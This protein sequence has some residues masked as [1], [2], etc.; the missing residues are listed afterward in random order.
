M[1]QKQSWSKQYSSSPLYPPTTVNSFFWLLF[2]R[3]LDKIWPRV[4]SVTAISR[5]KGDQIIWGHHLGGHSSVISHTLPQAAGCKWDWSTQITAIFNH[6]IL[7]ECGVAVGHCSISTSVNLWLLDKCMYV[8]GEKPTIKLKWVWN[9]FM[10]SESLQVNEI[11][12]A[13]INAF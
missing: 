8:K 9:V 2:Y 10:A 3:A 4:K 6:C 13:C 5:H 11:I 7:Q 1:N 12:T